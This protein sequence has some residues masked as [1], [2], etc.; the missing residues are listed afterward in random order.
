VKFEVETEF[1]RPIELGKYE[2]VTVR[3]PD[4]RTV[5]VYADSINVATEQDVID[6]KDGRKIWEA[7]SAERSPYGK[8]RPS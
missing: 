1:L 8:T 2:W 6:H 3:L 5:T 4:G 7:M